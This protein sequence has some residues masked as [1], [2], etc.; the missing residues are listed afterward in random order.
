MK[1]I[2]DFCFKGEERNELQ[3]TESPRGL[4]CGEE[5]EKDNTSFSGF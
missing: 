1:A 2:A 4:L 5:D 3:G